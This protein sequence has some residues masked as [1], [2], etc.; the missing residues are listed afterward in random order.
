M[1]WTLQ[2][3]QSRLRRFKDRARGEQALKQ[4]NNFGCGQGRCTYEGRKDRHALHPPGSE[5]TG[6]YV[7]S[8]EKPKDRGEG[9]LPHR[10]APL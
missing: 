10:E 7:K 1:T 5:V 3:C 4:A 9:H 2:M 6:Q 8:G